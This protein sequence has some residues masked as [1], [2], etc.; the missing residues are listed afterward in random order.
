MHT[1]TNMAVLAIIFS[2]LGAGAALTFFALGVMHIVPW[3]FVAALIA[4]PYFTNLNERRN[5]LEWKEDFGGGIECID[6]DH[7]Q[8][9]NLINQFE[10]AANYDQGEQFEEEA[11]SELV[12]YT[13][14]H[15]AIEEKL[16]QEHSYPEFEQHKAQHEAMI[17]QV[18]TFLES[19]QTDDSEQTIEEIAAYLKYWLVNHIISVD[20]KTARFLSEAGAQ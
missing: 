5:F 1:K 14:H 17:K 4:I 8:L 3:L 11:L 19:Y 13:K 7:K 20:K 16:M 2:F 18:K 10:A 9:I 6:D 12:D 15:F